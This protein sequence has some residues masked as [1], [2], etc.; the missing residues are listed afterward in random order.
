MKNIE[1]LETFNNLKST[2]FNDIK[3]GKFQYAISKNRAM[4]KEE[5][6]HIQSAIENMI[7]DTLKEYQKEL[8]ELINKEIAEKKIS[9][10][11]AESNVLDIWEKAE[12]YKKM[13][14]E[15]TPK[16]EKYY[17]GDS[18]L[19]P[20]KIELELIEKLPLN[21]QQMQAVFMLVDDSL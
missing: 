15:F 20:H 11:K 17:S 6:K 3:D 18:S 16:I 10:I 14:I 2:N 21:D 7:P 8:K 19:I 9:K 5:S 12:E 13:I 1:I 4:F